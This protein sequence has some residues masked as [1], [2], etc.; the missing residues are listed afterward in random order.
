MRLFNSLRNLTNK[1]VPKTETDKKIENFFPSFNVETNPDVSITRRNSTIRAASVSFQN[2][3]VTSGEVLPWG[4]QAVWRGEDISKRGNFASDTYAFVI[5]SGVSDKTG[6]INLASN[7][8]WHRS[9]I[10]G[11]SAFSDANGHGTHVAGTI[12][13]LVNGKGVVGVAPGAQIV[14]LKVYDANLVSSGS[15]VAEAVNY[16]ASIINSN[17]LDKSKVVINLSLSGTFDPKLNDAVIN[18]AN[19]GIRFSIA[20][21]NSGKDVDIFSPSSAGNH[22]NVFTVSAVDSNYTMPFWSNWDRVDANDIIDS[23]DFAAPGVGVL[24]Y[25]RDGGMAT[26]SGTSMAAPHVSGLL[27]TGGV[28]SGGF[29][30]PSYSNTS[31]AFAI[32]STLPYSDIPLTSI[33]TPVLPIPK[34]VATYNLSSPSTVNEG[35][36][37]KLDIKTENVDIN[38]RHYWYVSG[39]DIDVDDFTGLRLLEGSTLFNKD[40][41]ASVEIK[42]REDRKSEATEMLK[43]ELY[44]GRRAKVGEQIISIQDT[45][46]TPPPGVT[47][48]GTNGN[49]VITGGAGDDFLCGV[50]RTGTDLTSMGRGQIDI[51]TGGEGFDIFVLGDSRGAFY[52]D[53]IRA[54]H[55]MTDYAIIKDFTPGED[56]VQ[57]KKGNSYITEISDG[58]LHLYL[59]LNRN[60]RLQ[61][62]GGNR[63][64]LIA[65]FEGITFL[66]SSD[67]VLV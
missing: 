26:L 58:N 63:D 27:L 46:K 29:V 54:N 59:D 47:L 42:I 57:L 52:D 60:K 4:V 11:E 12:G 9:W 34:P 33:A 64:D 51:L 28:M 23:V 19:Q 48:W 36:S 31:D 5:D 3:S 65:I 39:D 40:G 17:S 43:F 13:S 10:T 22:A 7:L 45:S 14:S 55:G 2:Q 1:L 66:G 25:Y 32:S 8:N 44:D 49:D 41:S 53:G 38:H 67:S 21:G 16:A 6:D 35:Q 24:S 61:I 20:A 50:S 30:T 18:A 15:R 37:F 56:K 62:S